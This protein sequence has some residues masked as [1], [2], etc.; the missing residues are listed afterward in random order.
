MG[1]E[2]EIAVGGQLAKRRHEGIEESIGAPEQV[3]VRDVALDLEIPKTHV[4][5]SRNA[6]RL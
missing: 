2:R 4:T 6:F 5:N 1:A 3:G